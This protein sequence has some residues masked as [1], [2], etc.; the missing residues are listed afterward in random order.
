MNALKS[1]MQSA[2]CKCQQ[3]LENKKEQKR[4]VEP[5]VTISRQTGAG[6]IT[7]SQRLIKFLNEEDKETKA[8][9]ALFDKNLIAEV[10]KEHAFPHDYAKYMP[11]DRISEIKD[12]M[13][14]MF[15]LHPS[16]WTLVHKTSETILHLAKMGN[17]VLVGRG[18]SVIT[19]KFLTNGFHVRLIGSLPKRIQHIQDYYQMSWS[20]AE[21]FVRKEDVGRK[22]YLKDYFNKDID[23]PL[24]YDLMINTDNVSYQ[25][26]ANMIGHAIVERR[27]KTQCQTSAWK[28]LL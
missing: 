3:Y 26:A 2:L 21:D 6:G 12:L 5:F 14:E 15:G 7:V 9:W 22:L 27:V 1:E 8:L 20:Q 28:N 17:V 16:S 25:E 11:E 10:L 4:T 13:E 23:D 18:S 19:K 24:L